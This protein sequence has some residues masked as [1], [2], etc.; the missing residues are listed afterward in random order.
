MVQKLKEGE[1]P[2]VACP[3]CLTKMVFESSYIKYPY[4]KTEGDSELQ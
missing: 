1:M 3:E 2:G 4:R